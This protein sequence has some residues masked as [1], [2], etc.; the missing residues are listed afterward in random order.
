M[1]QK[2]TDFAVAQSGEKEVVHA[3]LHQCPVCAEKDY[4]TVDNKT[5]AIVCE[6]C[7]YDNSM[8]QK[9]KNVPLNL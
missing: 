7:G 5:G 6:S 4:I 3:E 8:T 9:F 1:V 2:E